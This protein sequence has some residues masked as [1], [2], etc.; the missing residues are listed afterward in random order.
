MSSHD[1][2]WG[3]LAPQGAAALCCRG[4]AHSPSPPLFPREVPELVIEI[5]RQD[6]PGAVLIRPRHPAVD[7][8]HALLMPFGLIDGPLNS[9]RNQELWPRNPLS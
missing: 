2:P 8:L 7:V 4:A 3:R 1:E 9:R 6:L 5:D